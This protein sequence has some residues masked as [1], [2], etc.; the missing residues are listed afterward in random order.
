MIRCPKQNCKSLGKVVDLNFAKL[1]QEGEPADK[2]ELLDKEGYCYVCGYGWILDVEEAGKLYDEYVKLR[3]EVDEMFVVYDPKK[4]LPR[5]PKPI[6]SEKLG[7]MKELATILT[8]E[9][10][11]NLDVSASEWFE[12]IRDAS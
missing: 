5:T 7:R 12:I 1:K 10:Q 9:H 11:H 2:S 8:T 3:Q 4:E 6:N